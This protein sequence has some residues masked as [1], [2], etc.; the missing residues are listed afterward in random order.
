MRGRDLKTIEYLFDPAFAPL[1]WPGTA[2]ALLVALLCAPLS[3]FVVLKKM[4]FI[5]QGVSH[6][7]FGGVGL[8]LYFSA[9][10]G[11]GGWGWW[12]Q[13]AVLLFAAGAGLWISVLGRRRGTDTAIGI[14]LAVCM[15]A[16]FE[17][18]RLAAGIASRDARVP[19]PPEIEE[20]L[21]GSVLDVSA[22]GAIGSGIAAVVVLLTL[23]WVRRPLVAWAF[24]EATAGSLGINGGRVRSLLLL[25]LAVAVVTTMQ[26]AGVV[27]ATAM[28][29]LPGVIGL[30]I[31]RTLRGAV[32]WSV[33]AGLV[34]VSVG[35]VLTFEFGVQ[36]GPSVVLVLA[37]LMLVSKLAGRSESS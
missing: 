1:F 2:A 20:L 26:I 13:F 27:L 9:L 34:G 37:V 11:S 25:M 24:D 18:Y 3:P 36:P 19:N 17:L 33:L 10:A 30:A 22:A 4:A 23:W 29:V 12:Q 21:F 8:V 35:L 16:G 6:A 5:G 15:A 28:L 14:V 32:V 31:G 7:A